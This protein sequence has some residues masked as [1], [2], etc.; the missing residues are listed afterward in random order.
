MSEDMLYY[1]VEEYLLNK[2]I[3]QG[4]EVTDITI[5][6]HLVIKI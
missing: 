5:T 6:L 3:A 4:L 1:V 2:D